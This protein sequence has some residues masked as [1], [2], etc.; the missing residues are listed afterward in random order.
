MVGLTEN[1]IVY[2]LNHLKQIWS[3]S[4][5]Y[6]VNPSAFQGIRKV[7]NSYMFCCPVHAETRPSCG[8]MNEYPFGWNC[9][10]CGSH[11]TLAKLVS[12]VIGGNEIYAEYYLEK[13]FYYDK[14]IEPPLKIKSLLYRID[15]LTKEKA[16]KTM[17]HAYVTEEEGLKYKGIKHSYMYQRGFNDRAIDRFE[18]GYDSRTDS[19]VFPVRDHRGRIRFL[20]R[21]AVGRKLF[22]NDVDVYKKDI[23]YGLYY[24]MQAPK[25]I[26][27]IYMVES[28]TD[29]VACYVSKKPAVALMGRIFFDEMLH[30]LK[31]AHIRKINLFLDN[32]TAGWD[33]MEKISKKLIRW[34]FEVTIPKHV[35][36][37]KDANELLIAGKLN[38]I[39]FVYPLELTLAEKLRSCNLGGS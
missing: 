13:L 18:L 20:Q 22:H 35:P 15:A 28:A 16:L 2:L 12:T 23:L 24:I 3:D 26:D 14:G 4:E 10:S 34:G 21:R 33:A 32:D 36:G 27:E 25:H 9:F 29:A 37:Y 30:P 39:R 7:G 1:D 11:G 6:L 31:V 8:I 19:I 17:G 38:E 5:N